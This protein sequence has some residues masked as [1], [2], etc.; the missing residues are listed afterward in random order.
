MNQDIFRN[1]TIISFGEVVF[2]DPG[3]QD[4]RLASGS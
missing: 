2:G 4:K 1:F 3:W